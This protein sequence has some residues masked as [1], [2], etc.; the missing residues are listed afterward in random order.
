MIVA[1]IYWSIMGVI[2][3]AMLVWFGKTLWHVHREHKDSVI[4]QDFVDLLLTALV[5]GRRA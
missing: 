3:T 4:K 5:N 1:I 2:L